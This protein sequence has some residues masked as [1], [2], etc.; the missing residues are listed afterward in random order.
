MRYKAVFFDRDNTLTYRDPEKLSRLIESWSG[1]PF[2]LD[3]EKSMALFDKAGYPKS[4]LKSVDEE[5]EFRIRYYSCL[6]E[7]EGIEDDCKN[8]AML[9]HNELWCGD[10]ALYPEVIEV[11]EYF[12][13]RGYKLGVISDTSPSLQLTLEALGLG[14]YFDCYICSDLV[15]VMKP[16]PAIYKAAL[17]ALNVTARESVYVDDYDVESDGA[18]DLG[19]TAFHID[20][21]NPPKNEWDI[22]SLTEVV[23]FIKSHGS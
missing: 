18:R 7:G 23:D 17:D 15:G 4:G 22:M 11:L 14:K 21:I 3:Y 5:I 12:K 1:K 16:D 10:R 20:R 13:T 19:F 2:V 6:L 8:K 9:L